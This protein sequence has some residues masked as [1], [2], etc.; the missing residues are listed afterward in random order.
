MIPAD[1]RKGV[2]DLFHEYGID[3]PFFVALEPA[4]AVGYGVD[5]YTKYVY[6]NGE[7]SYQH[8]FRDY[9]NV[10]FDLREAI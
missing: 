1:E 3:T 10:S 8:I 5:D 7:P 9:Y 4:N 2:Q 6:F